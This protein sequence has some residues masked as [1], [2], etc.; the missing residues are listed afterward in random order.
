MS[1]AEVIIERTQTNRDER[2]IEWVDGWLRARYRVVGT[3]SRYNKTEVMFV[4]EKDMFELFAR[5]YRSL[6]YMRWKLNSKAPIAIC[7][8]NECIDMSDYSDLLVFVSNYKIRQ[9]KKAKNIV[10]RLIK[11]DHVEGVSV[12][13]RFGLVAVNIGCY[14]IQLNVD[15]IIAL[16][17]ILLNKLYHVTNL[18]VL[19]DARDYVYK[20]F[21]PEE[22]DLSD[23]DINID[24]SIG[25]SLGIELD[26]CVR[27][28]TYDEVLKI[29]YKLLT[30]SIVNLD[31]NVYLLDEIETKVKVK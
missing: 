21:R 27:S 12:V 10:K 16:S 4:V 29:V 23:L 2:L 20:V 15:E 30:V 1:R 14:G 22:V 19:K 9:L 25:N 11:D 3:Y 17:G 28:F 7:G 13:S 5:M 18:K 6:H 26:G 31:V 24:D 8:G